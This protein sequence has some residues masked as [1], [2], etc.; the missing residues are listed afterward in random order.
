MIKIKNEL[1]FKM[2]MTVTDGIIEIKHPIQ[3]KLIQDLE[4]E[5]L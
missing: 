5:I 2:S 4:N 1:G 3:E